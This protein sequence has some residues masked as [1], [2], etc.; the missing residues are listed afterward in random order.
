VEGVS[1]ALYIAAYLSAVVDGTLEDKGTYPSES[2]RRGLRRYSREHPG[3]LVGA[4]C[5]VAG[6]AVDLASK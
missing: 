3:I 5:G 6:V 1:A 2:G 4:L